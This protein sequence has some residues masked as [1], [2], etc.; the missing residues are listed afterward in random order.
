M[1][2]EKA[3]KSKTDQTEPAPTGDDSWRDRVQ[4]GG[5][6]MHEAFARHVRALLADA[7]ISDEDR[8]KLLTNMSC[9]CCGGSA[10]SIT[11]QL[12]K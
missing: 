4:F 3:S 10:S 2:N 6:S 11:V 7:D 5:A 9:P 8:E 1:P 12:K